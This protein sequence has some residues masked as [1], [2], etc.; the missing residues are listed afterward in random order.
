MAQ[1]PAIVT[2]EVRRRKPV[3]ST[4]QILFMDFGFFGVWTAFGMEQMG[5]NPLFGFLHLN[6]AFLPLLNFAGSLTNIFFQPLLGVAS[7]GTWHERF[8]RRRPFFCVSAI[9]SAIV[10]FLFPLSFAL[11]MPI[12]L[13]WLLDTFN[14]TTIE[15]YRAF[16]ADKAPSSQL[17]RSFLTAAAFSG[18]G[19][20]IANLSMFVFR[21]FIAGATAA[22]V[23]YFMF[24]SFILAAVS[25][26]AAIW[27]AAIKTPENPPHLMGTSK[28]ELAERH[29][30]LKMAYTEYFDAVKAMPR[31]MHVIGAFY[32]FQWFAMFVFWQFESFSVAKT[33][34]NATPAN[35]TLYANAV[36]LT[37]LLNAAYNAFSIVVAVPLIALA[38][39]IGAKWVHAMCLTSAGLCLFFL[40]PHI[41]SPVLIFIPMIGVGMAWAGMMSVPMILV[42]SLVP[43]KRYGIYFGIVNTMQVTP[44]LIESI[45]FG[46]IFA[47]V[48]GADPTKAIMFSGAFFVIGGL[49]VPFV[50]V[51]RPEEESDHLPLHW[52]V[53]HLKVARVLNLPT[54]AAIEVLREGP[55]RWLPDFAQLDG[56]PTTELL[57]EEAG[58]SF[59]IQVRVKLGALIQ[60]DSTATLPIEWEAVEHQWLYPRLIGFVRVLDHNGRA[61]LRFDAR[62]VPPGG[63]LGWTLDRLVLGAIGRATLRHF[64]IRVTERITAS[65]ESGPQAPA[66]DRLGGQAPA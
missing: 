50:R 48:L 30:S 17:I 46:P 19:V 22:G 8:G 61:E 37:G 44:T 24:A 28:K 64:F 14:H 18:L 38:R 65:E 11:W 52:H 6:T 54:E 21:Q 31:G 9:G 45:I 29:F 66:T 16:I 7:D 26:A 47:H 40:F 25:V 5:V 55:Q 35:P 59:P 32:I 62:Y 2:G 33:V 23:P 57:V 12:L 13:M 43:A 56:D 53:R 10:L 36:A 39:R 1:A 58:L 42:A 3:L 63:R 4:A 27:I 41:S 51:P 60:L 49:I 34:F 20:C 15:S